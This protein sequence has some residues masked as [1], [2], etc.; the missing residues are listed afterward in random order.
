MTQP[1]TVSRSVE[2][3]APPEVAWALVSDLPRMGRLS[4]EN[5]GGRWLGGATGP[6]VGSRFRGANRRGL[7]RWSTAVQVVE[8]SPGRR[9]AFDVSSL[10]LAVARWAYD[11]APR[12]V[13]E[14]WLDRRGRLM[15]GIGLLAT[16]VADRE[17]YTATSIEQ[18]LAAVKRRAESS[19]DGE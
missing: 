2:V 1:P 3:D 11:V 5:A 19:A 12:G 6:A 17:S 4:P 15:T 14:T 18:T 8:C 13:T 16:G 9:F 10:G 7:R